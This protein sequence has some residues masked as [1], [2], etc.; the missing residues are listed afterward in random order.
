MVKLGT[1]VDAKALRKGAQS[2]EAKKVMSQLG[3]FSRARLR[4][5]LRDDRPW[6]KRHRGRIYAE[7][8]RR[9]VR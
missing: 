9:R 8:I 7:L 1:M 5:L 4:K 2:G 6:I 3:T